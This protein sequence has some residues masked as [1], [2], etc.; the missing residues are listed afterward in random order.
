[1]IAGA[2]LTTLLLGGFSLVVNRSGERV[3]DELLPALRGAGLLSPGVSETALRTA[4]SWAGFT[5][6]A[7]LL[8]SALAVLVVRRYPRRRVAAWPV[9]IAG[10]ACLLGSQL[11]LHPVAFLFFVSAA[12]LVLRQPRKETGR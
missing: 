10:V 5:V 9:G 3:G 6:V 11:A 12:L 4:A 7:V 8:L 2:V 1:M